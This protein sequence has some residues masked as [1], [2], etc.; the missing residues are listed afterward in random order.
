MR[1]NRMLF[2]E[3]RH[4]PT[5]SSSVSS[6]SIVNTTPG[7]WCFTYAINAARTSVCLSLRHTGPRG[8]YTRRRNGPGS[9][10][11]STCAAPSTASCS[12][13][14]R[15]R[16]AVQWCAALTSPQPHSC[17]GCPAI[18]WTIS[19]H[20]AGSSQF[21][22]VIIGLLYYVC[23]ILVTNTNT[24]KATDDHHL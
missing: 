22:P 11:T 15:T 23:A 4:F 20:N 8:T 1:A 5:T 19:S 17:K 16:C 12:S 3:R 13:V 21:F 6:G 2:G 18:S 9:V 7:R 10:R 14:K 24:W